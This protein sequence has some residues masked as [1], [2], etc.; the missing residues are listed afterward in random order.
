MTTETTATEA[1]TT[2]EATP[3]AAPAAPE[4]LVHGIAPAAEA[5][6]AEPVFTFA[7]KVLVKGAD[8]AEDWKATATKAEQ[9]RQHLERRLGTGETP[10]KDVGGYTFEVPKELEGFELAGDKVEAFKAEALKQGV[11]PGQFKWMMDSYLKAAPDLMGGVVTMQ[12]SQAREALAQVWQGD[13]LQANLQASQRAVQAMPQ[14]LQEAT[15]E[16]GTNPA[17]IRALAWMGSQMGE[18]RAPG[19]TQAAPAADVAALEMSEAYRNPRHPEHAKV[20]S[21]VRAHYAARYGSA[22]A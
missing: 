7:E 9:A 5:A 16:L 18:D 11:T 21:Q 12:A 15:L 22:P 17:F 20:S 19:N 1:A 13:T 8:G 10:P 6:P 14:D 3:A 4:S 2:T